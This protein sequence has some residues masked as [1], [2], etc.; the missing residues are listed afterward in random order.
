MPA[1]LKKKQSKIWKYLYSKFAYRE[2]KP[3]YC[4]IW[5]PLHFCGYCSNHWHS[6]HSR[7]MFLH[8][9]VSSLHNIP[10]FHIWDE[11]SAR[12]HIHHIFYDGHHIAYFHILRSYLTANTRVKRFWEWLIGTTNVY[13]MAS[14]ASGQDEQNRAMWLATRAGKMKPSCPLGTTRCIPQEKFPRKPYNKFFIDQV[15]SVKM[16]GYWPRSFLRVYGPRRSRAP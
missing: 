11:E 4:S 9:K 3:L 1:S 16:A 15:C 7:E 6:L 13:Y 12:C 14:S 2:R 10:T 8:C 5:R